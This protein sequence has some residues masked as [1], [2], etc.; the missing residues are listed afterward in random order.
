M[1]DG[2]FEDEFKR[3]VNMSTYLVAFIVAN[4]SHVSMNVSNTQVC[5]SALL[6][7]STF[8]YFVHPGKKFSW[9]M[10]RRLAFTDVC[11]LSILLK[12]LNRLSLLGVSHP[13]HFPQVSVYA[14]PD[15][16]DQV[17]YALQTAAKLLQFYNRFFE[18]EYPLSK[19]GE[20]GFTFYSHGTSGNGSVV[21]YGRVSVL[22]MFTNLP[23]LDVFLANSLA[24][25]RFANRLGGN[26]RLPGWSDGELGSHY[27]P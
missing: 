11:V 13:S 15:K 25:L 2:L 24:C 17:H 9:L 10:P 1:P 8:V 16:Q 22:K 7:Y 3:S 14:V 27:V 21:R 4:F 18:I 26:T 19:L 12:S 5:T 6:L 23:W 20:A